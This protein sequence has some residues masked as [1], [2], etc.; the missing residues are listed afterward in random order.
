MAAR[1]KD[2]DDAKVIS[3][4]VLEFIHHDNGVTGLK[5]TGNA[6]L[7][8]EKC[9]RSANGRES[10]R[11]REVKVRFDLSSQRPPATHKAAGETVDRAC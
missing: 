8:Y 2:L 1:R 3:P 9:S 10:W 11:W 4:A 5:P 6:S 7:L